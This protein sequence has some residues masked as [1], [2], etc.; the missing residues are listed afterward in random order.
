MHPPLCC[1]T[2]HDPGIGRRPNTVS[3]RRFPPPSQPVCVCVCLSAYVCMW[4]ARFPAVRRTVTMVTMV[5]VVTMVTM[6]T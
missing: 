4:I 1:D 3:P 6:V 2:A 5:T